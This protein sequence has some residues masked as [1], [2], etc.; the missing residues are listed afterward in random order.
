MEST[1]RYLL[2]WPAFD[3]FVTQNAWAWPLAETAHFI[4]LILLIGAVG[5][6]DLRILGLAKQIPI[7]PLRRLLPWGVFG[8]SLCVLSGMTFV[9]AI[10]SNFGTHPYNVLTTNVWLQL[11][12][13]FILLAGLNLAAFYV[14]GMSRAVE[15]L[16]ANDDAPLLA[17][18]IAG[19]SVFL[20]AGVIY[21]G[22]LIPWDVG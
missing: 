11:K 1:L 22:R 8:F 4:G 18:G 21:L 6:F 16:R 5:L 10:P 17:R 20:W 9:A 7:A 19:V 3:L 15:S 12:L 2:D 14:T 13:L